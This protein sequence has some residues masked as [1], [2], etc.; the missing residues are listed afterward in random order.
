MYIFDLQTSDTPDPV[1][2][3]IYE[4]TVTINRNSTPIDYAYQ[5]MAQ[6]ANDINRKTYFFTRKYHK[7]RGT[8]SKVEYSYFNY[9]VEYHMQLDINKPRYP[10][11]HAQIFLPV[12]LDNQQ[13]NNWIKEFQ[14]K[15][16]RTSLFCTNKEDKMHKNDHFEG[17][18]SEYLK[19]DKIQN[20]AN[21]MQHY[22]TV[23]T[24]IYTNSFVEKEPTTNLMLE[25]N[26][27][28]TILNYL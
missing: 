15:Y 14:R 3:F 12:L 24:P 8:H 19:K 25:M 21:G 28:R 13:F 18:W 6:I 5:K 10:H 2:Y 20:E 23:R 9:C 4:L 1:D 22:F 17:R 27:G 16:G 7:K 26:H 11:I